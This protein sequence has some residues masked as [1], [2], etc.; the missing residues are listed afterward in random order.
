MK[1]LPVIV[2]DMDDEEARMTSLVENVQRKDLDIDEEARF[3]AALKNEYDLSEKEIRVRI[4]KS[5]T[6][7]A[8]KT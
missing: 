5:Q 7:V 6:Y 1:R 3:L 8:K 2:H 4:N